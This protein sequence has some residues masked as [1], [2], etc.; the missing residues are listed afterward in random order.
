MIMM[1]NRR[2]NAGKEKGAG[3]TNKLSK[4]HSIFGLGNRLACTWSLVEHGTDG[5]SERVDFGNA[6]SRQRLGAYHVRDR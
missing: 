1:V 3:L 5:Y 2:E 4:E 6:A